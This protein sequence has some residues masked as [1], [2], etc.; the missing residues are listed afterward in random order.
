MAQQKIWGRHKGTVGGNGGEQGRQGSHPFFLPD[1]PPFIV[2]T[3]QTQLNFP[4]DIYPFSW[5]SSSRHSPF[6]PASPVCFPSPLEGL[7]AKGGHLVQKSKLFRE[8]GVFFRTFSA[9]LPSFCRTFS[10]RL[11]PFFHNRFAARFGGAWR[12]SPEI[13]M[14]S[15]KQRLFAVRFPYIFHAFSVHLPY[16]FRTLIDRTVDQE[17]PGSYHLPRNAFVPCLRPQSPLV[18]SPLSRDAWVQLPG[19]QG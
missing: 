19:H 1:F 17:C 14:V 12:F 15:K 13:P 18:P 11:P 10:V 8:N 3:V 4:A 7:P 16:F 6:P 2:S 9:F 5:W